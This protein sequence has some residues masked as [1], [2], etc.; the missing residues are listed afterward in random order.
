MAS[1]TPI[2][3]TSGLPSVT[4]KD[5]IIL[6]LRLPSAKAAGIDAIVQG[7]LDEGEL[8][9]DQLEHLGVLT[10]SL[11]NDLEQLAA[12]LDEIGVTN[13]GRRG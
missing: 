13:G 4:G 11:A 7:G 8:A 6:L 3:A 5:Q 10:A 12:F 2:A 9:P 1:Q